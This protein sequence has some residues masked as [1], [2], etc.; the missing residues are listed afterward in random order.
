[1]EKKQCK[2]HVLCLPYPTQGHINPLTQ[3]GKRLASKGLKVTIAI[4]T[5]VANSDST[6]T[7]PE[8]LT[9]SESSVHFDTISDGFDHGGWS[10]A[11]GSD[12]YLARFQAAGSET[13][14]KLIEKHA[15]S[16]SPINCIVYDSFLPWVLDVAK[17]HGVSGAPFF[18]QA[19]A[20]NWIY[21][22]LHHGLL[23]MPIT[24]SSV[25]LPGLPPLKAVDLPSFVTSPESYPTYLDMVLK[26]HVNVDTA[27]F[28]IVN[29]FY[30]LEAEV[31]DAM[32]KQSPVIPIGPTIPSLYLDNRIKDNKVYGLNLFGPSDNNSITWLNTKP[33]G[34]VVYISFG[35]LADL[36]FRQMEELA[37]GIGAAGFHFLW[38]IRCSEEESKL[39]RYFIDQTSDRG[40]IVKWTPQVEVLANEAVGCFFSHCGWNSTTEALS[41]GV[42]MVGMPQWT[43]QPPDAKLIEDVWK[44]GVRVKE[45][46]EGIVKREEIE[47]CI[48]KVMEGEQ[49]KEYKAN[50]KRWSCLAKE[51]V[52]P[53]GSSDKNVDEFI[54]KISSLVG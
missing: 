16:S 25:E 20:V 21:Y 46:E 29:T 31:I 43:D 17:Q 37:W 33:P 28:V 19:C 11:G 27:D 53:G 3:F 35:S 1:M 5:F 7:I 38:S 36:E 6:S 51:A 23:K 24:S 26:Q 50:A 54:T 47:A 41:L 40:L 48:R 15:G 9:A 52:S 39:P 12:V 22:Y 45:N 34:S 4:T 2:G 10:K 30:E 44:I 8:E 32:R 42:P 49:G 13:L 18:T 14:S